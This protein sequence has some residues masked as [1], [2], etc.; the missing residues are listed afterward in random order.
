MAS[1]SVDPADCGGYYLHSAHSWREGF[2]YLRKRVC[3]GT[4]VINP[5]KPIGKTINQIREDLGL[6]EYESDHKHSYK[7]TDAFSFGPKRETDIVWYCECGN[8]FVT[9]RRIWHTTGITYDVY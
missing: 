9:E 7:L 4:A 5:P 3:R 8:Y 1:E 6:P 2:L